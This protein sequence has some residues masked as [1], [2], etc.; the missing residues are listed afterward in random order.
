MAYLGISPL[1]VTTGTVPSSAVTTTS[2]ADGAVTSEKLEADITVAGN[3]TV[4]GTTTTVNSTTLTVDDKNIE[5]AS[6]DSPSDSTANLGGIT[7]KGTT[8]KT[9]TYYSPTDTWKYNKGIDI[10]GNVSVSGGYVE[11]A[12]IIASG[13]SANTSYLITDGS[14]HYHT[15]NST[16]NC[17][18]DLQGFSSLGTGNAQTIAILVTNNTAPKYIST[19]IVDGT[20]TGVTTKWSGG[21]TPSSGNASNIDTYVF[22]VIKTGASTYTV[23]AS[24]TQ[25]GG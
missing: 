16:A 14:V 8:D 3:L 24:Q 1:A 18:V 13:I 11:K 23:L 22:N 6:V 25:F 19:V 7:L 2:I 5:L 9:I 20:G 4:S 10:A 12:N 17:T 15:G 21:T